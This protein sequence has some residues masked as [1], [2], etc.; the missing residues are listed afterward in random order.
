M[1]LNVKKWEKACSFNGRVC[2]MREE[3]EIS[4]YVGEKVRKRGRENEEERERGR[5]EVRI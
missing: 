1:K 2:V 4:L 5:E 3:R